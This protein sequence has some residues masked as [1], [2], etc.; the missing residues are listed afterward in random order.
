MKEEILGK[1]VQSYQ[2]QCWQCWKISSAFLAKQQQQ[3]LTEGHNHSSAVD[4]VANL[5]HQHWDV[6]TVILAKQT[7]LTILKAQN[8]WHMNVMTFDTCWSLPKIMVQTQSSKGP[9]DQ[10]A[11]SWSEGQTSDLT[12]ECQSF[13]QKTNN[14]S[15]DTKDSFGYSK[16]EE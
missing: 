2:H 4:S 9:L 1:M 8:M 7:G 11:A 15:W 13:A 6:G 5:T 16:H 12:R 3:Q 10:L 14:G